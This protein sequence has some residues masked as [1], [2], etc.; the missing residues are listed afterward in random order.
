[1]LLAFAP[2]LNLVGVDL[3]LQAQAESAAHH[4]HGHDGHHHAGPDH[5]GHGHSNHDHSGLAHHASGN[6]CLQCLVLGGMS[7]AGAASAPDPAPQLHTISTGW[8]CASLTWDS[9]GA[10][11]LVCRG[12][13]ALA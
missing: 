11:I 12:P 9:R 5:S 7:L 4:A 1:M 2:P 13:P 8:I 3:A 6:A 10:K